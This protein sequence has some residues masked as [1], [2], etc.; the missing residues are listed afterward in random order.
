MLQNP[1]QSGW[2]FAEAVIDAGRDLCLRYAHESNHDGDRGQKHPR[3]GHHYASFTQMILA[4]AIGSPPAAHA[5]RGVCSRPQRRLEFVS[6]RL[7][8]WHPP[9]SLPHDDRRAFVAHT[10]LTTSEDGSTFLI[11]LQL[12][13]AGREP[14]GQCALRTLCSRRRIGECPQASAPA[15]DW[16]VRP[17][18]AG[19]VRRIA[20]CPRTATA[21]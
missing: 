1:R 10:S 9:R 15:R 21:L 6:L 17:G 14:H 20:W 13:F 3:C 2:S 19:R 4:C 8:E 16:T 5:P 7:I 11:H 18:S 12:S